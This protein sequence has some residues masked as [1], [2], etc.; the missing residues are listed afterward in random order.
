V[1]ALTV[2][3]GLAALIRVIVRHWILP[4]L[5]RRGP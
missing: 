5:A 4:L 3:G 2:L 1:A